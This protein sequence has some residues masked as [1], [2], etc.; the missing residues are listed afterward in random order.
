M[1]IEPFRWLAGVVAAHEGREVAGRT[2]LQKEIKLLQR[3]NLPTR[4]HYTIH[5]YG[6]YSEGVQAEI[7]L[8]EMLGLAKEA[9]NQTQDGTTYYTIRA[10]ENADLPEIEP[11][12]SYIKTME[13]ADTT[14]LELAA[15]YDAFREMGA[16]HNEALQRL[17]R[18]KGAKCND[19]RDSKA[20]ELL[21]SLGLESS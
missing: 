1:G 16:N 6:P 15:T 2:R 13:N 10:T 4:Y 17:K 20:L 12:V 7:G 14:V 19:G 11:F 9:S 3:L 18:K 5:F 21:A 8:L